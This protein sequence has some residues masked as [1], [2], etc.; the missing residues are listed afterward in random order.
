VGIT[1]MPDG[2]GARQRDV[3]IVVQELG[4]HELQ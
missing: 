3:G 4:P 2:T 1:A